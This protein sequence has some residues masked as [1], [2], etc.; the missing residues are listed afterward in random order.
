LLLLGG[1][2]KVADFGLARVLEGV[3]ASHSGALTPA[4]AA[5]EFFE[6]RTTP[7]SDQYS[8]AVTFCHLRGSRLPFTGNHAAL[9]AAHLS[10]KPD[11]TMLPEDEQP[12]VAR[13]LAKNPS[14]RWP[15][16]QA[17]VNALGNFA[18]RDKS[19]PLA[20][21]DIM[22]AVPQASFDPVLP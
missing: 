3:A 1:T 16:C 17:F 15:S 7:W 5:P 22:R 11:L 19:V 10:K 4:Y 8:L 12:A 21:G 9:M 14:D 20:L 6:G 2:V 13:A 18:R